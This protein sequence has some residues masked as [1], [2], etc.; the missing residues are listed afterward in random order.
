MGNARVLTVD[1]FERDQ[2]TNRENLLERWQVQES[3]ARA[4]QPVRI[5]R[6]QDKGLSIL[7]R[8]LYSFM[9]IL[10]AHQLCRRRPGEVRETV[11]DYRFYDAS[12]AR[13]AMDFPVGVPC[14]NYRF[15]TT[16]ISSAGHLHLEVRYRKQ[17]Q[18]DPQPFPHSF[19]GGGATAGGGGGGGGGSSRGGG[20]AGGGAGFGGGLAFGNAGAAPAGNG[21]PPLHPQ[22][23]PQQHSGTGSSRAVGT[24]HSDSDDG[25]GGGGGG[26]RG[27]PADLSTLVLAGASGKRE[28]ATHRAA[29]ST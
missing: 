2:M 1:V 11:I 26:G 23:H 12:K 17:P 8:S 7:L 20:G 16:E 4:Q 6:V 29:L 21:T 22:R 24:P 25:S 9:R 14:A 3:A 15:P 18:L 5:N 19:D 10:P 28:L 13:P 27:S